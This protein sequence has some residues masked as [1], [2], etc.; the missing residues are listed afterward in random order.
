M[1]ALD[2]IEVKEGVDQDTVDAVTA[3]S[4]N[5]KYGWETEIEMDYAPQRRE[6]RYR[7]PD[8]I[9]E[10]R[11]RMDDRMASAGVRALG[12]DD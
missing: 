7:A 9:Q 10:R 1:T 5:Y 2:K 11:T 8:F 4:G 12:A 6:P 3:L